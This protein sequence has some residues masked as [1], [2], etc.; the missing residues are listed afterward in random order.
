MAQDADISYGQL[1]L[2]GVILCCTSL[3]QDA[4]TK[5]EQVSVQMGAVYKLDLTSD[6]THL[7]VGNVATPKYRYV[8]KERPDVRVL[9]P[10]WIGSV[11]QAW[12]NGED[13][14]LPTLEA[15]HKLPAFFGLQMCVTGFDNLDQRNYISAKAEEQGARYHDDLT[16]QVSHLITAIP[17]GAKYTHA[18][19]WG[20]PVVSLKWFEE[21]LKRG[22]ALDESLYDPTLPIEAQ[23]KGAFKTALP[24]PRTSLGKRTRGNGSQ[25]LEDFGKRRLRRTASTRLS[26]QSQDMWQDFSAAGSFVGDVKKTNG[27]QEPE[28][29]TASEAG[30]PRKIGVQVDNTVVDHGTEQ[31]VQAR[32]EGLFGGWHIHIYGFPSSRAAHLKEYLKANGATILSHHS[33]L[34]N[35]SVQPFFLNRCLLVPHSPAEGMRDIPKVPPGTSLATEWWVERCLHFK[36]QLEPD[37]DPLSQPLWITPAPG[38]ASLTISTTGFQNLDLRQAAEAVK[39]VGATYSEKLLPSC[40]VLVT[41]TAPLRREKA[42]YASKHG[43]PVVKQEW[44]WDCLRTKRKA[45]FDKYKIDAPVYD[46]KQFQQ[47]S[48]TDSPE[49]S[50]GVPE[51]R[52]DQLA[53]SKDEKPAQHRLSSTRRRL[54]TASLPMQAHTPTARPPDPP[55]KQMRRQLFQEDEDDGIDLA[56]ESR[57]TPAPELP[58]QSEPLQELSPNRSPRAS[59]NK[60]VLPNGTAKDKDEPSQQSRAQQDAQS[61]ESPPPPASDVTTAQPPSVPRPQE[62]LTANLQSLL[63]RQRQNQQQAATIINNA[64]DPS[65]P[66]SASPSKRKRHQPLGRATSGLSARS[67]SLPASDPETAAAPYPRSSSAAARASATAA[68]PPQNTQLTYETP[69]AE[70][71]RMQMAELMGARMEDE[72]LKGVVQKIG[73]VK[74]AEASGGGGDGAG[75]VGGRVKG[76]TRGARPKAEKDGW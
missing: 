37:I 6:V 36:K 12:M 66:N 15:K 28:Q 33:D 54:V 76:R 74:D 7:I 75:G 14:D 34:E 13:V 18:R 31:H 65:R 40:S 67:L 19:Q 46:P 44:L 50:D 27:W 23:G 73:V 39:L 58:P 45:S 3:T 11:H 41:G 5:A 16:K 64:T 59:R 57:T 25:S 17:Q 8:A 21:S 38:L 43:I 68:M 35:A 70:P 9:H 20:I 56:M 72:R 61:S 10:E 32:M 49:P 29:Q 1:P 48:A 63:A 62:A 4:R 69:D 26:S 60:P 71:H 30:K 47:E 51:R 53:S 52:I 55:K 42:L 2:K 24:Q 22:M